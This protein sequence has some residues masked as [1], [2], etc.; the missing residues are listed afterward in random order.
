[1][2]RKLLFVDAMNRCDDSGRELRPTHG[3]RQ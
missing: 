1:V 2:V 3:D